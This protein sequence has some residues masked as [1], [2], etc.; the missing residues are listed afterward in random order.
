[1]ERVLTNG[2]KSGRQLQLDHQWLYLYEMNQLLVSMLHRTTG[3]FDGGIK[4]I[5]EVLIKLM[6]LKERIEKEDDNI[7]WF[8][9]IL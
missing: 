3:W 4:A 8:D 9:V 7:E 1:M 6:D 5:N 2:L